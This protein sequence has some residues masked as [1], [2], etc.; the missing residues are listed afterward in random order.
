M[1]ARTHDV[2]LTPWQVAWSV[3]ALVLT[4]VLAT[5]AAMPLY[6][7]SRLGVVTLAGALVGAAPVVLGWALRWRWWVILPA[8]VLA[9]TL[10][11]VPVAIPG[12]LT[13]P[14]RVLRGVGDGLVGIVLG[15]KRLLTIDLPAQTYQGVLVPYFVT[16]VAGSA[17]A[18]AL[19]LFGRRWA[20]FAV[21]PMLAMVAF[22]AVF[23]TSATGDA[24]AVG[25]LDVPA[26]GH[27]AVGGSAVLVC[28][29][30]LLGRARIERADALRHARAQGGAV[31]T[32]GA[33]F[34]Y[35]ARRQLLGGGL[36]VLTLG[37]ALALA[38]LTAAWG[39]RQ[40]PRDDVN[41][42]LLLS[43]Q[44]S[45]LSSYRLWF[46]TASFDSELFSVTGAAG[47]DRIR[48]ATLNAYDGQTFHVTG[49]TGDVTF[50]RQ[51]R[52]QDAQVTVTIGPAYEGVWVPLADVGD[53]APQFGGPRAELLGKS[54]YASQALDAGV[55]VLPEDVPP[56]LRAGDVIA[57]AAVSSPD[58]DRLARAAG[59]NPLILEEDYPAL[60]AWVD[61]QNVGRS[62]ADLIEL[63]ERLRSRG[64][65]SHGTR[66]DAAASAWVADLRSRADYAF[67]GSRAGHSGARIDEAFTALLDQER[68]AG[69]LATEAQLVAAVGNDEQ[70]AT[71]SALLAQYLG[72]PARVVVGVRLG[73]GTPE[74]GVLPCTQVCTGANVT[75]W[76][77]VR[78]SSG[79]WYPLDATPQFTVVPNL[80]QEGQDPPRHP[81]EPEQVEADVIEPPS[82]VT[83]T[84]SSGEQGDVVEEPWSNRV[85]PVLTAV[86]TVV[87]GSL[88]VGAPLLIFPLT[89]WARRRWRRHAA[90]DE[91]RIVG[92]WD[93]L[94]D[95]Y[96]DLGF[97]IPQGL[98]RL[99]LA[100][101]LERPHATELALVADRAV[102]A[103][104]PPEA[105]SGNHAWELVRAEKQQVAGL[106][107]W[108]RRLRSLFTPASLVRTLRTQA[109]TTTPTLR[110]K[111]RHA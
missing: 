6:G 66:N 69:S 37:G 88:L 25:P 57:F 72:F 81:T 108:G 93:E 46:S 105:D 76:A 13:G 27:V 104:H 8:I 29:I 30:W 55:V 15:W 56:G 50:A 74:Q 31:R 85:L 5:A 60:A 103:A 78:D 33:S 80:L 71:A 102:F 1:A 32:G 65:L 91:V 86:V 54:Y 100:D 22:G 42:L 14:D 35:T 94:I 18:V 67:L 43:S 82:S 53:G 16:V 10:A 97:N 111:D 45:P 106:V 75:V 62:G 89:K 77:E 52:Q 9:Y 84:S 107:P 20:P 28:L 95:T 4:L 68:R 87:I 39:E 48:L 63:V 34:G 83:D 23:G 98:T 70:F 3:G 47:V 58:L 41:P 26:P 64:Y 11:V 12:A 49:R 17:T 79:T 109:T 73:D 59:G 51:P 2:P 40:V 90:T 44:P 19:I 7:T 38:P 99:E 24:A 61:Q 21:V 101:V 92:A 96:V 36:V 110:R